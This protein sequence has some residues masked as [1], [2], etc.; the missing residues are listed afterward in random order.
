M[1]ESSR[2]AITAVNVFFFWLRFVLPRRREFLR[3]PEN[4]YRE[5]LW[6]SH[7]ASSLTHAS[8]EFEQPCTQSLDLRRAPRLRKLQQAKQVDQVVGK[9]M[10]EQTEGVGQ[11]AVTAEPV[12]VK[13]VFELLDAVFA[14]AAITVKG[15]ELGSAAGHD[16]IDALLQQH[17]RVM[18]HPARFS[19]IA[20]ELDQVVGQMMAFVKS[21]QRQQAGITGDLASGKIT[22][23]GTMAVEGEMEL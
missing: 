3:S 17:Q 9:A 23:N 11:E 20:E 8:A 18:A 1:S 22:V 15:K 6:R 4:G 19:R 21:P 16:L 14:F 13:A 5:P 2:R 7:A 12:G 10:Q